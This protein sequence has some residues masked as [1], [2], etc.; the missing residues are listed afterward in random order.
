MLKLK[1]CFL[2]LRDVQSAKLL[3]TAWQ[4]IDPTSLNLPW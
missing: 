3:P 2:A 1:N 4:F